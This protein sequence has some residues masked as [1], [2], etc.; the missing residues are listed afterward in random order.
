[1]AHIGVIMALEE[2][3]I[4]IDL[5]AGTSA[6][7]IIG[8]LHAAGYSGSEIREIMKKIDWD[9]IFNEAPNPRALWISQRYGLRQPLIKLHFAFWQI[10]LPRGLINGQHISEELFRQTMAANYAAGSNFDNLAVPF[11]STAVDIS[12]GKLYILEEGSLAQAI[13]ASTSIPAYYYPTIFDDKLMV[14]GGVLDMVPVDVTKKMGAD[15][16]IAVKVH[17]TIAK[18]KEPQNIVEILENML[19]IMIAELGVKHLPLADVWIEPDLGKHSSLDY[20]DIDS[21][22]E[23]GYIAAQENMVEIKNL[24]AGYARREIPSNQKLD[25]MALERATVTKIRIIGH[26]RGQQKSKEAGD[27]KEPAE[28]KFA[29]QKLIQHYFPIS[30][31]DEFDTEKALQGVEDLYATGLFQNVWLELDNPGDGNVEVNIHCLYESSHFLGLGGN[32]RNEEGMSG[33]IQL[34]PLNLHRLGDRIM[35]FFSFGKLKMTAGLEVSINRFLMSP[36]SLDTGFHYEKEKPYQYSE[37]GDN[38]GQLEF[39]KALGKLSIGYQSSKNFLFSLGFRGGHARLGENSPLGLN[40]GSFNYLTIFGKVI[41]DS[42]DDM[43]FP[44]RGIQL[45]LENETVLTT[46]S[47]GQYFTKFTGSFSWTGFLFLNQTITPFA[48][49]GLSGDRLPVYEKFRVGGPMDMPGFHR[50]E[51]WENNMIVFGLKH[52][53]PLFKGLN[54]QT[55]LSVASVFERLK[56]L[57]AETFIAGI[58]SGLALSSPIGPISLEYGWSGTGRNQYYLSVGYDF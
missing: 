40:Y 20:S 49:W 8:G 58:S 26:T 42:T 16:I 14:D 55:T 6:G 39:E 43:Y 13:R 9:Y 35:P 18:S 48:K 31:G 56:N 51:V 53:I 37:A 45:I 23:K 34:V 10:F 4:P 19:D 47:Q 11:R 33:F 3:G 15:V 22:I 30:L 24:L 46:S 36:F 27:L 32:Y 17:Q 28:P 25:T 1:M 5:I 2:A 44:T 7:S 29:G 12:T 50:D 38:L 54:L 52:R 41:F 57:E 21:I